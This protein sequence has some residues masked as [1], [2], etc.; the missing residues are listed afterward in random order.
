MSVSDCNITVA[1]C[2]Y[3][4]A[5]VL[6]QTL[7]SYKGIKLPNGVKVELL[8]VDNNSTDNTSV[9]V[10]DLIK[11]DDSVRYTFEPNPGLSNARNT[12]IKVSNGNIIAFVDDDVF[13]HSDWLEVLV[14]VFE[15]NQECVSLGGKVLPHFEIAKPDWLPDDK[16]WIYGVTRYGDIEIP[17]EPPNIPIGCNMAFRK[18]IFDKIG[19]FNVE[20][21]RI[22]NN[23][24]SG[25][26]N[27]IFNEIADIG[28]LVLY[29]PD[30]IV[31]HRIPEYRLTERWV[32]DR[33][34]WH[35]ISEVSMT[36]LGKSPLSRKFLVINS[37]NAVISIIKV[38]FG[39]S[40]NIKN[41]YWS[42]AQ[43]SMHK[44]IQMAIYYGVIKQ[45]L[46]F[47]FK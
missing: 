16:L 4:R 24:L 32:L 42:I 34:F 31:Y 39:S 30:V 21:G 13:F 28:G 10:N 23:L 14:D 17:L 1:I 43:F 5:E 9:V 29:S 46:I 35:G 25:E 18:Q 36:Q 40:L 3:N 44:R 37:I 45:S 19:L 2:T 20:L 33:F 7:Q 22:G 6:M 47:V 12:A 8:V 15:R 11:L 38:I 41:I 26:E 27:A